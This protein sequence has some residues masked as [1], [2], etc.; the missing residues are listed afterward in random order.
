MTGLQQ[1]I[2]RGRDQLIF[3]GTGQ[4]IPRKLLLSEQVKW[5]VLI[6]RVDDVITIQR[7]VVLLQIKVRVSA[8]LVVS[9]HILAINSD[10][11]HNIY[12]PKPSMRL[13]GLAD[14]NI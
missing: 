10:E 1:A 4:Q 7:R 12:H 5:L 3:A 13:A 14:M 2:V 8:D 9:Q 6:E 11:N